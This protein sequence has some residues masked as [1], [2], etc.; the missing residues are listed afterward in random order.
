[1][2]ARRISTAK[3]PTASGRRDGTTGA[4]KN[5]NRLRDIRSSTARG[6]EERATDARHG[7]N[8]FPKQSP[9]PSR[10]KPYSPAPMAGNPEPSIIPAM[11]LLEQ[12]V[13]SPRLPQY[14]DELK[15]ILAAERAKRE[16]FFDELREDQKAEFIN[17]EVIVQSP[18]T[19]DHDGASASIYKVFSVYV[20]V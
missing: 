12:I 9:Q 19:M 17:G 8:S 5:A 16:K 4:E 6:R 1:M 18:V 7:L 2:P 11:T 20:D 14:V 3:F 13:H 10:A 15:E